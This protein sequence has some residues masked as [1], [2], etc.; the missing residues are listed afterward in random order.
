MHDLTILSLSKN[1]NNLYTKDDI[2][3]FSRR[4]VFSKE[5]RATALEESNCVCFLATTSGP[6]VSAE[7]VATRDISISFGHNLLVYLQHVTN[8]FFGHTDTGGR[9]QSPPDAPVTSYCRKPGPCSQY[10]L[11]LGRYC[12]HC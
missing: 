12:R 10:G 5:P 6:F 8:S 11:E 3:L 1:E 9:V 2:D 4:H 7:L